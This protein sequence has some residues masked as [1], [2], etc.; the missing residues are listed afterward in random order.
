MTKKTR[1]R[2]DA[3]LKAKI[4]LEALRE[5]GD[6]YR[7]GS[8]L[9]GPSEPDLRLEE[10]TAGSGGARLRRGR[11]ARRRNG[12]RAGDRAP[13]RQDWPAHGGAGS[14]I[15]SGTSFLARRSGR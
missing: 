11:R 14:P 1:R 3:G 2:I 7:P 8:A 12:A 13:A 4:A 6:G 10:A 5:Q 9:R 15:R